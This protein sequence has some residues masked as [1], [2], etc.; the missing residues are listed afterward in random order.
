[1][2]S[3]VSSLSLQPLNE[4]TNER[5]NKQKTTHSNTRYG[6]SRRIRHTGVLP[7][8]PLHSKWKFNFV[9]IQENIFP[10]NM[11]W[12]IVCLLDLHRASH[13]AIVFGTLSFVYMSLVIYI[14][15]RLKKWINDRTWHN[16]RTNSF[17]MKII[18][19]SYYL[20]LFIDIKILYFT[21]LILYFA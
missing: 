4:R 8:I 15:S 17:E 1:M 14:I 18:F 9:S 19:L 12:L 16:N 7:Y 11:K 13:Q 10:I 2:I 3:L 20:I 21:L 5:T 6:N